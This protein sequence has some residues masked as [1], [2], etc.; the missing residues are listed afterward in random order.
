M[1]RA[2]KTLGLGRLRNLERA[3]PKRRDQR[4]QLGDMIHVDIK[5]LA[6]F[7]RVGYRISD[8]RQLGSSRGTGDEKAHVAIDDATRLAY[9]QVLTDEKQATMVGFLVRTV[10]WFDERGIRFKRVLSDNGSTYRS[11]PWKEVCTLLGLIP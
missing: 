2:L 11:K 4:A 5:H 3:E 1:G 6:R 10:A 7:D 9:V 8:G